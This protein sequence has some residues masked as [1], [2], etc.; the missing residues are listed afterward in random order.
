MIKSQ[1]SEELGRFIKGNKLNAKWRSGEEASRGNRNDNNRQHQYNRAR[2]MFGYPDMKRDRR[3]TRNIECI[4]TRN[5]L[6]STLT[7]M[8]SDIL[9]IDRITDTWSRPRPLPSSNKNDKRRFCRFHNDHRHDTNSC[10][11]LKKEIEKAIN[12]GKLDHFLQ[13]A[14]R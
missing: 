1:F 2:S 14:K 13:A 6:L 7:K 4:I 3:N 10:R 5:N 9:M 11:E 12:Q 8:S